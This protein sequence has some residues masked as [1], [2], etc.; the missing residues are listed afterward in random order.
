MSL[1]QSKTDAVT[2]NFDDEGQL[3][4]VLARG[5]ISAKSTY[6]SLKQLVESNP[7]VIVKVP[8]AHPRVLTK[9][10]ALGGFSAAGE[11]EDLVLIPPWLNRSLLGRLRSR[12]AGDT[13]L[14]VTRRVK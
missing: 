13:H 8:G 12:G 2:V 5:G 6:D 10:K 9:R 4:D 11:P 14:G 7:L 1:N 3:N